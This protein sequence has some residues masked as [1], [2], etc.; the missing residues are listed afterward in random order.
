MKNV[1]NITS[2]CTLVSA[3]SFITD[4]VMLSSRTEVSFLDSNIST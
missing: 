2:S 4:N 1:S 3:V